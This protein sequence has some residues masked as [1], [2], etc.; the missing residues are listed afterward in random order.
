M[1]ITPETI[2]AAADTLLAQGQE[3]TLAAVRTAVGGGSFTTI[4]EAM[5]QW[6][7]R[8]EAARRPAVIPPPAALQDAGAALIAEVWQ[9]AQTAAEARLEQERAALAAAR[10]AL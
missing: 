8:R 5:K 7:A 1:A 6:R 4:S 9:Q 10:A 3:P 2:F